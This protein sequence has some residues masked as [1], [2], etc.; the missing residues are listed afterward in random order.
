MKSLLAVTLLAVTLT[1]WGCGAAP[2]RAARAEQNRQIYEIY[3]QYQEAMNQE[4]QQAGLPPRPVRS[5]EE[6]RRAP[7]AD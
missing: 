1:S 4:R 5:Y 6:F 2:R 3:R 7:A